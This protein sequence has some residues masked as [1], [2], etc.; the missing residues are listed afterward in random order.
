MSQ[1]YD[2]DIAAANNNS[3]PPNGAPEFMEYEQVNDTMRELMAA[4]KRWQV[5]G[6]S[7]I[8]SAGT[9]P[10]YTLTSGQ[11]L[12]V[13][14]NGQS[15]AFLAHATSTGNVTLNVDGLG[16]VAVRDSRG[17]QLGSGDIQA[18]GIYVVT[19]TAASWRCVGHFGRTSI[20]ALVGTTLASAPTTGGTSNAFT[21]TTGVLTAY[22]NGQVVAFVA[23]RANTGASTI[24]V[25][26]LGA[27][28]LLDIDGA[29]LAS[30]DIATNQGHIAFRIGGAWRI[31]AGLPVNLATQVV[32]SLGLTN[33]GTGGASGAAGA[34]NLAQF[35]AGFGTFTS[36]ASAGTTDLG[37]IATHAVNITGTTTIT[38]FG[39]SASTALPIYRLKFASA[40][41]ITHNATSL[42]IPGGGSLSVAANDALVVE[43]LGSGNWRVLS[44]HPANPAQSV[45]CANGLTILNN[46]GT[47]TTRIDVATTGRSILEN[48]DGGTISVAPFSATIDAATNGVNG[49]DTGGLANSTWYYEWIISNGITTA[50]L[51]STSSTAP[52]MPGGYT[53]KLRV[54]AIR[55][56][57]SAQFLRKNQRGNRASYRT[58]SGTTLTNYPTMIT[59][60]SGNPATPTW[61]AVAYATFVPPTANA[62]QGILTAVSSS[63]FT[64]VIASPN[65]NAG[66]APP[67]A[68]S[69]SGGTANTLFMA[70]DFLLED[71]TNIYYASSNGGGSSMACTGWT[72][73]VNAS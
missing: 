23:D 62:I 24:D 13:Y 54:G 67:P 22:A 61:T 69:V 42:I 14:A 33:G 1:I 60:S 63:G 12:A 46:A 31:I 44:H 48:T 2:Y 43:Y 57:A 70:F 40:L 10:A 50:A 27:E 32:G 64:S 36:L 11:S 4:L 56:N 25:D 53:F 73:T 29:A 35:G 26:G 47:P 7:G 3:A 71:P 51:L 28:S 18:N 65:N 45:G 21:V 5:A 55:T 9:Q 6:F 15:F 17:N 66:I 38:A 8:A 41:Q 59:G 34:S 52:T 37:T 68:S 58:A 49:L 30:G 19:K 39:S 16:A 72:D 20:Q